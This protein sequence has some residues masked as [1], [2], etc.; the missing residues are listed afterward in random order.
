MTPLQTIS[1]QY[2]SASKYIR[3]TEKNC[4]NNKLENEFLSKNSTQEKKFTKYR[5]INWI[6][7][8]IVVKKLL[9]FRQLAFSTT[10]KLGYNELLATSHFCSL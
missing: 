4:S 8:V 2:L 6:A 10:V 5:Q 9:V 1:K 3:G 7:P